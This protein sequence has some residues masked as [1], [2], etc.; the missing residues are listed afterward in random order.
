MRFASV[1]REIFLLGYLT[2]FICVGVTF[3][4]CGKAKSFKIRSPIWHYDFC[5]QQLGML[6][7][8][9]VANYFFKCPFCKIN[10]VVG[11]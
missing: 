4:K 6:F 8:I 11:L 2:I 3:I 5:R 9:F 10:I 1:F 7:T